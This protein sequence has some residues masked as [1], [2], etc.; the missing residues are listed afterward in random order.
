M[1]PVF[2]RIALSF[3][4][5]GAW[6]AGATFLGER[7]GSRKAGLIA[8]MPSNILISLLFMSL[9]KGPDYA[10]A[11]TAGVPMGMMIDAVFLAVFIFALRGGVWV[12]LA[13][14]LAAWAL[15]A[16]AVITL[17]PPLGF[18]ASIAVY[19]IVTAGLFLLVNKALGPM[20]VEKKPVV[21]SWKVVAL[22]AFFAG[23]VV[24]GAVAVAQVAPPY[25]T[26]VLA[27]F[28]AVLTST[29]VILARSQSPAFAQATGKILILSSCN[30]IVYA[31]CVGILFP[32]IGPWLGTLASFAASACFIAL[33]GRL[34]AKVR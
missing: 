30:I 19:L 25:M 10:A 13:A 24:A 6:I 20:N 3:F 28:P 29:M 34:T 18:A 33:L 14:S 31:A 16:L 5:A 26:G 9:T 17:V 21:F 1:N 23:T 12:A 4:I 15:I 32:L 11:A 7:L 8:N 2:T 22:R 27:T